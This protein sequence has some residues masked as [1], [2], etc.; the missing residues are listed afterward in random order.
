MLG[1]RLSTIV[2]SIVGSPTTVNSGITP[3]SLYFVPVLLFTKL[4]SLRFARH[5]SAASM[6]F[7]S[8]RPPSLLFRRIQSF[9]RFSLPSSVWGLLLSRVTDCPG[10]FISRSPELLRSPGPACRFGSCNNSLTPPFLAK[11]R[12]AH[13]FVSRLRFALSALAPYPAP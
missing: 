4:A 6:A 1:V 7:S 5:P 11:S 3:Y 8:P 13:S 12:D 2:L 10:L 9:A